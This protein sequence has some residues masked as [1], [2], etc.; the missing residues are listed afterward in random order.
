MHALAVPL[1]LPS[2]PQYVTFIGRFRQLAGRQVPVVPRQPD[3]PY[4]QKSSGEPQSAVF[5]Q[6]EPEAPTPLGTLGDF[7]DAAVTRVVARMNGSA[8]FIPSVRASVVE[9]LAIST[10]C[11]IPALLTVGDSVEH[12]VPAGV[13]AFAGRSVGRRR[14]R[15]QR[16]LDRSRRDRKKLTPSELHL[17]AC[18]R[19]E[20]RE[21]LPRPPIV[22]AWSCCCPAP[23]TT[24]RWRRLAAHHHDVGVRN[25]AT[26]PA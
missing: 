4:S 17:L 22:G 2:H 9:D 18:P 11:S 1:V 10:R 19:W 26:T 8:R 23:C 12:L 15:D 3:V 7:A 6:D 13:F 25:F 14:R 5:T 16:L 21:R 20:Q 24:T